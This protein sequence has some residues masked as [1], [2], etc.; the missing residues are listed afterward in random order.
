MTKLLD[1]EDGDSIVV[2]FDLSVTRI[3]RVITFDSAQ[4][5]LTV[6]IK[7]PSHNNEGEIK[8]KVKLC[9]HR[10]ERHGGFFP[11]KN[12]DGKKQQEKHEKSISHYCGYVCFSSAFPPKNGEKQ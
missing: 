9:L 8:Y 1:D 5:I 3:D 12:R 6:F 4:Q 2:S 11:A 10:T 7:N